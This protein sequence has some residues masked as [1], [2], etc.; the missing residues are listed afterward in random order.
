ML[1]VGCLDN[2]EQ[3]PYLSKHH[4][5]QSFRADDPFVWGWKA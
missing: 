3:P 2:L 1:R 5:G 4:V